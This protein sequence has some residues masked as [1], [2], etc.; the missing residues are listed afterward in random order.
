MDLEWKDVNNPWVAWAGLWSHVPN[1]GLPDTITL[2]EHY[3]ED[4]D[5]CRRELVATHEMGHAHGLDESF[6]GN[7]MVPVINSDTPCNMGDH[8]EEDYEALWGP[9]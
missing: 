6:A 5:A 3:M 9:S 1:N 8:D 2:N 4:F 7:M